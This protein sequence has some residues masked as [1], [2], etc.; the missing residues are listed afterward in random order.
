MPRYSFPERQV[1][2][3]G[4]ERDETRSDVIIDRV[5]KKVERKGGTGLVWQRGV[6]NRASLPLELFLILYDRKT[7]CYGR[8][9]R[10]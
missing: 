4:S 6:E 1:K 7:G 5:W 10:L 8:H 2:R 9:R 3:E